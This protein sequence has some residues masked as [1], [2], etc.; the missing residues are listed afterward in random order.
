PTVYMSDD[1]DEESVQEMSGISGPSAPVQ[2]SQAG[3]SNPRHHG[4]SCNACGINP[5]QGTRYHCLECDAHG[6]TNLCAGCYSS[7]YYRNEH[8][9][10]SHSFRPVEIPEMATT[11]YHHS[12]QAFQNSHSAS[13]HGSP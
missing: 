1:D 8:H 3:P 13:L 7:G 2:S 9:L 6:G 11:L 4:Y 10:L 5:I 12:Q